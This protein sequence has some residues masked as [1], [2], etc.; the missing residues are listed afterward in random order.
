MTVARFAMLLPLAL[1]C[2]TGCSSVSEKDEKIVEV[3][4]SATGKD[5]KPLDGVSISFIPLSEG[6]NTAD[7]PVVKGKFSG[8]LATGK[9]TYFYIEGKSKAAF[10]AIPDSYK[11]TN[12]ERTFVVKSSTDSLTFKVE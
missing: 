10:N 4:G 8:K 2:L 6:A 7:M 3:S 5:G 12:A 9:Y 1:G 11:E